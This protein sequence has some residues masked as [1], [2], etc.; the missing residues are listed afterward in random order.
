MRHLVTGL[1]GFGLSM[2]FGV[3]LVAMARRV[4]RGSGRS[5]L[6]LQAV[7][8]ALVGCAAV[9]FI[10]GPAAFFTRLLLGGVGLL[11]IASVASG[12]EAWTAFRATRAEDRPAT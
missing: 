7:G 2:S 11:V 1:V 3:M 6:L 12:W 5:S 9:R 10:V 4:P 8:V